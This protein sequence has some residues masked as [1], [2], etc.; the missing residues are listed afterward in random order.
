M[1]IAVLVFGIIG[2]IFAGTFVFSTLAITS[3]SEITQTISGAN[4][5]SEPSEES[6]NVKKKTALALTQIIANLIGCILFWKSTAKKNQKSIWLLASAPILSLFAAGIG[7][8]TFFHGLAC[9][10]ALTDDQNKESQEKISSRR[11]GITSACAGLLIISFFL[12]VASINDSS[13]SW[14]E[15]ISLLNHHTFI[16][17]GIFTA[18]IL[19]LLFGLIS[20]ISSNKK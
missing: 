18:I 19:I 14:Y 12:P 8:S 20:I 6:D 10:L 15:V 13:I 9:T 16:K 4:D 3:V 1:K 11:L 2:C 7:L 5:T 17:G